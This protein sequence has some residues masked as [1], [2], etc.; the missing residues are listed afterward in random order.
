MVDIASTWYS[1]CLSMACSKDRKQGVCPYMMF[2]DPEVAKIEELIED[3]V[4]D[5]KKKKK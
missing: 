2:S 5:K 4:K 1:F 3:I